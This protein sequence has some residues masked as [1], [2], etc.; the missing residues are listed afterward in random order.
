[1]VGGKWMNK[2]KLNCDGSVERF[3][4]QLVAQGY[5]EVS[6]IDF[7][8]TFTPAIIKPTTF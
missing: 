8:E 7:D 3:K 2:T 6:G 1:M 4:A 5:T